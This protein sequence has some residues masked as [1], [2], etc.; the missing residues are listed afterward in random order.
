M[1]ASGGR[2]KQASTESVSAAAAGMQQI[3]EEPVD[4]EDKE[5]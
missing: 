4:N 3:V 1:V 5:F 2:I